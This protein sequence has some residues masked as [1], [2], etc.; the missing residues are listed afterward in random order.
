MRFF[1]PFLIVLLVLTSV[2]AD[3]VSEQY[4]DIQKKLKDQEQKIKAAERIEKSFLAQIDDL[5]R[6]IDEKSRE[7]RR[8]H[9]KIGKTQKRIG[10]V[11]DD[12]ML[13]RK[14]IDKQRDYLKRKLASMQRYGSEL[15][16]VFTAVISSTNFSQML[17]NMRYLEKIAEYDYRQI[18]EYRENVKKLEE[19][20]K[21]L[22]GLY[23]QLKEEEE[24]LRVQ[25]EQLEVE[26]TNKNNLLA[27][28]RKQKSGYRQMLDELTAASNRLKDMLVDQDKEEYT[29]TKFALLKGR[30]PWPVKG[31]IAIPYGSYRDPKFNTPVFRRGIYIRADK[32]EMA[33]AVYAGKVVYADW[34]KGYGKVIIVNHGSGYHSVY[35]N[36]SEIFFRSGDTVRKREAIGRVG[37]SGTIDAPALYFEFRYKGR[38]L[39][40]LQWLARLK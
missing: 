38:P 25:Q 34:F 28:V 29:L 16:N 33:K 35:A 12:I 39:N 36:L 18:Q 9:E 5:N 19:K 37:E 8:Q 10:L 21:N 26:R 17:R 15:T 7:L 14:K 30:L 32:G 11:K 1:A 4:R 27:S 22:E 31:P 24:T 2:S 20:K 23:A 3:D 40:P 13:F 6:R